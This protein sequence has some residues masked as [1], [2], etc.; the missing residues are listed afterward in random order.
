M[1]NGFGYHEWL[2]FCE[3]IGAEPLYV[4]NV[5][6]SCA[7]RSG[8]FLPDSELPSLI[9]NTLDAIEYAIGPSTSKWGAMRAKNGH[10]EPFPMRIVEIGNEQQ[11]PRYGERVR[12]FTE[13]VSR[14]LAAYAP[15][16]AGLSI[17][18]D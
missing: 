5:G 11:G 3:D 14:R 18:R 2:Q 12:L 13:F 6:V 10:P 1:S 7:F 17:S 9:Q 8:T 16:L 15:L 4:F